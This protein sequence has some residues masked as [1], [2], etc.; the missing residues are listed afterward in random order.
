MQAPGPTWRHPCLQGRLKSGGPY[1][2]LLAVRARLVGPMPGG[3][4]LVPE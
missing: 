1:P 4:V 2:L 3:A